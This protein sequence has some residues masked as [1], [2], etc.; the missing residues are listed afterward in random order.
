MEVEPPVAA[1]N[2]PASEEDFV[3]VEASEVQGVVGDASPAPEPP[4]A[5]AEADEDM[6]VEIQQEKRPEIKLEDLFDGM[7]SD[8]DEFSSSSK[9]A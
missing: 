1:A 9:P 5:Q 6:G 3:M 7:D 8:D 4:S 2:S